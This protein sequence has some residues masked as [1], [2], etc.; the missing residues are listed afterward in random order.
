MGYQLLPDNRATCS[1]SRANT[2]LLTKAASGNTQYWDTKVP[3]GAAGRGRYNTTHELM[4]TKAGET[5]RHAPPPL[6]IF[7]RESADRTKNTRL[8]SVNA[9]DMGGVDVTRSDF[10]S[11]KR[12][13]PGRSTG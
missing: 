7:P 12:M 1:N 13:I 6:P 3:N 8:V 4:R 9:A 5:R 2:S 10:A 11:D